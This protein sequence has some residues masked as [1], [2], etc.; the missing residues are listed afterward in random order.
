MIILTNTTDKI[1]V[2]LGGSTTTNQL[3]CF[4]SYRDT[5]TSSITPLRNVLNTNNA[6]AV[7]LV[8]APASST[9]RIVDYL[10]VFN[11]D[12]ANQTVTIQFDDNGTDYELFVATLAPGEKIEFQE[13]LGF[14][15][16]TNAGSVKTSVNQGNVPVSS[17]LQAATLGSD[18]INNNAVG[19]TIQDV[20]GLSFPVLTGKAYYFKFYINYSAATTTTGSRWSISGPTFTSLCYMS[21]YSLTTT[22]TTRNANVIN[23][24]LPATTNSSSGQLVGNYAIIEGYIIPSADGTVIAR[25]ASEVANS[26]ITAKAGSVVYYQQ[27]T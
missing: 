9:Q 12:T 5:T 3:R 1:Q 18:V 6:T 26:A 22:T 8:A 15:V 23:Y 7:D 4:A 13:G 2:I 25:C 11:S 16:M 21:E 14:K 19:N 17:T 27:L 20:T 24:N 10:S